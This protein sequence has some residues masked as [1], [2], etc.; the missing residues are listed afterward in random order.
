MIYDIFEEKKNPC[1][2]KCII[3]N[4][5]II[6]KKILPSDYFN[7]QYELI[8]NER[9]KR[10]IDYNLVCRLGVR[11]EL[12][13]PFGTLDPCFFV[14][15][16]GT[17]D[18]CFFFCLLQRKIFFLL[19]P[20]IPAFFEALRNPGTLLLFWP[21]N[22]GS[23]VWKWGLEPCGTLKKKTLPTNGMTY[24]GG[25]TSWHAQWN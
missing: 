22:P 18:P 16:F 9:T 12:F 13:W 17:I 21:W 24:H 1:V 7:R 10:K 3:S 20:W 14:R 23:L 11:W 8:K 25:M 19:E 6:S 5:C 4:V 2:L 15:P